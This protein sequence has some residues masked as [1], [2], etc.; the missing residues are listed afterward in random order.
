MFNAPFSTFYISICSLQKD[1]KGRYL[2]DK[3]CEV[4][5][6]EEKD[7]FGLRYVDGE[8][9]R[10]SYYGIASCMTHVYK[11][12]TCMFSQLCYSIK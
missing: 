1:A 12:S 5:S 8:K 9:Q 6:L 11:M 2:L 3:A 4:Q 10:V 7:Y